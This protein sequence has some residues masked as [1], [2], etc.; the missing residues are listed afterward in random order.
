MNWYIIHFKMN[1]PPYVCT[2]VCPTEVCR[3][4]LSLI[5]ASLSFSPICW[6]VFT[7]GSSQ[8]R[9]AHNVILWM[10]S[11]AYSS[12]ETLLSLWGV[13]AEFHTVNIEYMCHLRPLALFI[14]ALS[15]CVRPQPHRV[16]D[17]SS[18][19]NWNTS[20]LVAPNMATVQPHLWISKRS[21]PLLPH[22][23]VLFLFSLSTFVSC[24]A[25]LFSFHFLF[26]SSSVIKDSSPW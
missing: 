3:Y 7:C 19:K 18:D 21:H 9:E 12:S 10:Q 24:A 6:C 20:F 11:Q 1:V 23:A 25:H 13:T 14:S 26:Q 5:I 22:F 8:T 2:Y 4:Q 17:V 16:L 15:Q